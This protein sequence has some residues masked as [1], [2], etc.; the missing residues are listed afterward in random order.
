MKIWTYH[1]TYSLFLNVYFLTIILFFFQII[2]FNTVMH[3]HTVTLKSHWGWNGG[4]EKIK[5]QVLHPKW[6]WAKGG[7]EWPLRDKLLVGRRQAGWG[8][9]VLAWAAALGDSHLWLLLQFDVDHWEVS[10]KQHHWWICTFHFSVFCSD[11][12][13]CHLLR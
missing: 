8:W 1:W 10:V 6:Q 12:F 7:A 3:I 13:G 5:R 9:G 2:C 11:V 4:R